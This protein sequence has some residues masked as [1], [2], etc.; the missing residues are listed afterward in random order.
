[1]QKWEYLYILRRRLWEKEKLLEG[2]IKAGEWVNTIESAA[3]TE[4]FRYQ[5]LTEALDSL[6]E[7]GWELVSIAPQSSYMGQHT[8]GFTS[9]EKWV[10]K[11]RKE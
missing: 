1:M 10:F 3:G 5:T 2:W 9:D 7:Q 4:E 6:G 11:R 8:A